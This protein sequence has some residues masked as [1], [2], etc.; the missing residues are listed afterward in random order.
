MQHENL[1][2]NSTRI[3]PAFPAWGIDLRETIKILFGEYKI[4]GSII[5]LLHYIQI[6]TEMRDWGLF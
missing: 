4:Q 6:G 5:H 3:L 2:Y 1:I